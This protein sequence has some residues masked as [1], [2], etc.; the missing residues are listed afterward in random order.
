MR[1]TVLTA[2]TLGLVGC[3][4]DSDPEDESVQQAIPTVDQTTGDDDTQPAEEASEDDALLTLFLTLHVQM[5]EANEEMLALDGTTLTHSLG[6]CRQCKSTR[7]P[8]RSTTA[9]MP[10]AS[11]AGPASS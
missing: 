5:V 11:S 8:R 6:A 10:W 1:D 9:T 2:A 7:T 3:C 4:S